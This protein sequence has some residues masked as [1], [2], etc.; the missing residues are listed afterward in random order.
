MLLAK[1]M[2]IFEAALN[3]KITGRIQKKL[4][5]NG[6]FRW[7]WTEGKFTF[8]TKIAKLWTINVRAPYLMNID[9]KILFF[10]L[11]VQSTSLGRTKFSTIWELS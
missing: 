2:G 9:G 8:K 3:Q 7:E 5:V 10:L 1:V 6:F 4:R 11:R